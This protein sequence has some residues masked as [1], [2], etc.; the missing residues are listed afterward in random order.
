MTQLLRHNPVIAQCQCFT[1]SPQSDTVFSRGEPLSHP[2]KLELII[3]AASSDELPLTRRL[4][5]DWVGLT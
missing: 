1:T 4:F 3:V 2:T 5:R